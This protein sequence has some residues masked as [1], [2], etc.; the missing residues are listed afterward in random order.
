MIILP[1]KKQ[2]KIIALQHICTFLFAYNKTFVRNTMLKSHGKCFLAHMIMT[3]NQCSNFHLPELVAGTQLYCCFFSPESQPLSLALFSI[4]VSEVM[5]HQGGFCSC[6]GDLYDQ[7][8]HK[9][10]LLVKISLLYFSTNELGNTFYQH[11]VKRVPT[12]F[13]SGTGFIYSLGICVTRAVQFT[14]F[15]SFLGDPCDQESKRR[16]S[17]HGL[18]F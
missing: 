3:F 13:H 6:P 18:G 10:K 17:I 5:F 1:K 15:H 8:S 2:Q 16:A 11:K 12:R 9:H 4:S 7:C 14:S